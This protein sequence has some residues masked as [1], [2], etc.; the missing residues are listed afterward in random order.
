MPKNLSAVLLGPL[1]T[2]CPHGFPLTFFP[3]QFAGLFCPDDEL[4][5]VELIIFVDIEVAHML[6][7]G[8]EERNERLAI[9]S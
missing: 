8:R 2:P 5:F 1:Y 4:D 7:L 3:W 6:L 9:F